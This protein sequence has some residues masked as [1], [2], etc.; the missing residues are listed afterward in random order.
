[1]NVVAK[2]NRLV[3]IDITRGIGIACIVLCHLF[4]PT[5]LIHK[6]LLLFNIPLF[7]FVSGFL[8][9][10]EE[11]NRIYLIK[12]FR[13]FMVPYFAV[14]ILVYPILLL[15]YFPSDYSSEYIKVDVVSYLLGGQLLRQVVNNIFVAMWFLSCL[16]FVQVI[17]NFIQTTFKPPIVHFIV[18]VFFIAAYINGICFPDFW[19]YWCANVA[20]MA[21]P[22]YHIGFLLRQIDLDKYSVWIIIGGVL[23]LLSIVFFP[24]NSFD[25]MI[26]YY[27]IPVI[28][29]VCSVL[30]FCMI[31]A[32]SVYISRN[33]ILTKISSE[34]GKASLVIM[35][36]HL[37]V[38]QL[39]WKYFE[40]KAP[41]ASVLMMIIPYCLY[42]IFD[43]FK[44]TQILFLGKY[45]NK[46]IQK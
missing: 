31:R 36:F 15:A 20:L 1:M 16:F 7:F 22:M 18:I 14:F 43:K 27:G 37:P 32:I 24:Q 45:R 11:N 39:L 21:I 13:S 12:K 2:E 17:Y 4:A 26:N 6:I 23:S 8:Y 25:M 33:K 29:L 5:L 10:K 3:W 35:A 41:P 30:C 38:Y 44:V 42:F 34:F 46:Q 19:L 9:K 40:I 28:T